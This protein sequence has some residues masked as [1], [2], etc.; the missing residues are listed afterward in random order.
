MTADRVEE[1]LVLLREV[2]GVVEHQQVGKEHWFRI[3]AYPGVDDLGWSPEPM[4]VAFHSQAGHP[5]QDP[6]GIYVPAG[7]RVGGRPPGNAKDPAAKQP[8]FSGRWAVLSWTVESSTWRPKANARAGS[9]L[10]NFALG[11]IE[12]FRSGR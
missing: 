7:A 11:F 2:F 1:E 12:R 6:Y 8:P 9:N 10:V 3:P 5:G 4:P